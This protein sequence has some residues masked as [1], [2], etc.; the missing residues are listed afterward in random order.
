MPLP[1]SFIRGQAHLFVDQSALGVYVDSVILATFI[2]PESHPGTW[3]PRLGRPA[4]PDQCFRFVRMWTL[5]LTGWGLGGGWCWSSLLKYSYCIIDRFQ[6]FLGKKG[7]EER[8]WSIQLIILW[9][10]IC[11]SNTPHLNDSICCGTTFTF[12]P[13]INR[14][15]SGWQLLSLNPVY[16]DESIANNLCLSN[17]V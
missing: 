1:S 8:S 11:V 17:H 10:R 4:S 3:Y 5:T 7:S 6:N 14:W 12:K 13:C 16:I 15:I 9:L 2:F